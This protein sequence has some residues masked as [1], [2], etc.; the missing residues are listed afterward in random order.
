ML[1][2]NSLRS[3]RADAIAHASVDPRFDD[4]STL[5]F[6]NIFDEPSVAA[7]H[8]TSTTP[9]LPSGPLHRI[10]TEEILGHSLENTESQCAAPTFAKAQ[11]AGVTKDVARQCVAISYRHEH[12]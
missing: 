12:H 4:S 7:S 2:D 6:D 9:R 8:R 1:L 3:H 10:T 11:R 5:L